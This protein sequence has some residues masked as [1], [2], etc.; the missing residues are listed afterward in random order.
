MLGSRFLKKTYSFFLK[1]NR[2]FGF[3]SKDGAGCVN[4]FFMVLPILKLGIF[5]N[6]RKNAAFQSILMNPSLL[7]NLSLLK[8][9]YSAKNHSS[10]NSYLED[11]FPNDYYIYSI[12]LNMKSEKPLYAKNFLD[13]IKVKIQ[14]DNVRR[15]F[16]SIGKKNYPSLLFFS[17]LGC[18]Y[19]LIEKQTKQLNEIIFQYD[20]D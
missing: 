3:V 10:K 9:L 13:K 6:Y 18:F 14:D 11:N 7:F 2:S 16:I 4:G 8:R 15:I 17:T 20:V 19:P 1:D 12:A 5:D